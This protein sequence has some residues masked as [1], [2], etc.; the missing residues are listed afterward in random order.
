MGYSGVQPGP[1]HADDAVQQSLVVPTSPL[2]LIGSEKCRNQAS[3][4]RHTASTSIH[5]AAPFKDDAFCRLLLSFGS[6]YPAMRLCHV[7][8][9]PLTDY[10]RFAP[11]SDVS[12]LDANEFAAC[13][14]C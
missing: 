8:W 13:L 14:R 4:S 3:F 6:L 1:C 12:A 10:S 9:R 7:S 11:T 5:V 2:G